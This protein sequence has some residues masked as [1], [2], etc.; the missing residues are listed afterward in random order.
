MRRHVAIRIFLA[1]AI[2]VAFFAGASILFSQAR[3]VQTPPRAVPR[4]PDGKP[5]FSGFWSKP[6]QPG[7]QGT[8]TVFTK[9]KMATFV[10]GGEALFYEPRTGDPRHDEP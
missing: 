4:R 2:V 9:S 8:A 5:D 1:S 7:T 3:Q 10:P 6:T